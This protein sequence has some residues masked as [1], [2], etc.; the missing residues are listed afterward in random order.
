MRRPAGTESNKKWQPTD[1]S[2]APFFLRMPAV[3]CDVCGNKWSTAR[4]LPATN[5]S[6]LPRSLIE[7]IQASEVLD[8]TEFRSLRSAVAEALSVTDE[9][10]IF[11]GT[12]FGQAR[13][14]FR[15]TNNLPDFIWDWSGIVLVSPKTVSILKE[16]RVTGYVILPPLFED[17]DGPLDEA[18]GYQELLIIG[19]AGTPDT[20]PDYGPRFRCE[21]CGYSTYGPLTSV[22]VRLEEWDGSDMS[23][24]D[25]GPAFRL[26]TSRVAHLARLHNLSNVEFI[27]LSEVLPPPLRS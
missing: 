2:D 22:R 12:S 14:R 1:A 20:N 7:R 4:R 21:A 25:R 18:A 26:T 19:S 9:T 6:R 23:C 8:V 27:P 17:T 11:P 5:L 24:F 13:V 3:S 16:Y 15:R 10:M